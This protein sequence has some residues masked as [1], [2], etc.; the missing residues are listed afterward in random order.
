[1]LFYA[2]YDIVIGGKLKNEIEKIFLKRL[3]AKTESEIETSIV[4]NFDNTTF[5]FHNV[6]SVLIFFLLHHVH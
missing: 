4:I 2:R 6:N 5:L 1:M 3:A